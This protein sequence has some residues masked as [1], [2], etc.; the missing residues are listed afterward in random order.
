MART[1]SCATAGS[2]SGEAETP[3]RSLSAGASVAVEASRSQDLAE[4]EAASGRAWG[5]GM[6]VNSG[7]GGV[8]LGGGGGPVS[9]GEAGAAAR[10][11]PRSRREEGRMR[12]S[13]DRSRVPLFF[14]LLGVWF[15]HV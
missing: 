4:I 12:G 5:G 3:R 10:S 15:C 11:Q 8:G 13:I 7:G 2:W 6:G 14:C 1:R 9:G